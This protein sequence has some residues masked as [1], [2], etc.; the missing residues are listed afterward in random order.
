MAGR[1]PREFD[2]P[3]AG[4]KASIALRDFP[5]GT[6]RSLIFTFA[7]GLGDVFVA[8]EAVAGLRRWLKREDPRGRHE[9]IGLFSPAHR[10]QFAR[11]LEAFPVLDQFAT[12]TALRSLRLRHRPLVLDATPWGC[13]L[14]GIQ[15]GGYLDL[16]W[17]KWGIPSRF[18]APARDPLVARFR[19][20]LR[21]AARSELPA[22]R[23]A[24]RRGYVLL[25]PDSV[26]L[27]G[28]K[29]WPVASWSA[30]VREVLR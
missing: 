11:V 25:A 15:L 5:L 23:A 16:Q 21:A 30:L 1:L 2:E 27:G 22:W 18:Q 26:Y 20:T 6:S 24:R 3:T 28:K 12:N 10:E 4:V 14:E 7:G 13:R 19:R 29:S 8:L 9:L 17:A